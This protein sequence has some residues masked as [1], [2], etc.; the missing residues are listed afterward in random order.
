MTLQ[1]IAFLVA[2]VAALA[3]PAAARAAELPFASSLELGFATLPSASYA[4]SGVATAGAP[5]GHLQSLALPAAFAVAQLTRSI[6]DPNLFPIAGIQL[7]L[8]N[9]AGSATRSGGV[10][11]GVLPLRGL[12]RLCLQEPCS[13]LSPA[14]LTI[15]LTVGEPSTQTVDFLVTLTI[16]GAAWTTGTASAYGV[17]AHGFAHGPASATSSTAAPSGVVSLVTPI[18]VSTGTLAVADLPQH[19]PSYARLTLHFVPEP[20]TALLLAG[21]CAALALAWRRRSARGQ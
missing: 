2:L 13:P 15:P 1:R 11:G 14:N 7:D 3:A 19:F 9:E 18:F 6:G 16:Q 8:A 12:A 4:G 10:L 20:A 21:G 5:D 17:T